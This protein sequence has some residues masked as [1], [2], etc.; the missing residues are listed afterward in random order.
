MQQLGPSFGEMNIAPATPSE[1]LPPL[2]EEVDDVHIFPNEIQMQQHGIVSYMAGFNVNVRVYL[3]YSTLA[4]SEMA[5][6]ADELFDWNRQ[7]YIFEQCLQRCREVFSNIPDV[8]Q[9]AP[10]G[11]PQAFLPQQRQPYYPPMPEF[12][13]LRV[14]NLQS[15]NAPAPS[16]NRR[17]EIQKANI[18]ASHLATRSFLVEKYFVLLDKARKAKLH[19]A[20]EGSANGL[21]VGLDRLLGGAN[22]NIENLEKAMSEE[23]EQVFRDLL[24]VL[25]SIDMVNME[26][27]GDSFV[28]VPIYLHNSDLIYEAGEDVAVLYKTSDLFCSKILSPIPSLRFTSM[29]TQKIRSIASTLLE[30]PRERQGDM[31]MQHQDYLYKFL[32]ILSKLERANPEG[33]GSHSGVLDE[34]TELRLWADLREQQLRFQN[35]GGVYGC[36]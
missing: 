24:V 28:S 31:A 22:A 2:P 13:E 4:T 27:N 12:S 15:H 3:S 7:Q 1:P 9:V 8:L 26:P 11:G 6:G 36:A 25:G 19:A 29:Q 35:Q 20:A 32:E 23:R 5:F 16:E 17:Y 30:V 33:S 10:R 34:E 18:Y 21:A 14:P